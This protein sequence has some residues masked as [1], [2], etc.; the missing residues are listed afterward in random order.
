MSYF[1]K[2]KNDQFG[3]V[4]ILSLLGVMVITLSV[5]VLTSRLAISELQMM[6]GGGAMDQTY[7]AAE[8]GLNEALYRLIKSPGVSNY[9]FDISGVTIQRSPSLN[10]FLA[11][12]ILSP[13]RRRK[14]STRAF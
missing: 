6:R 12:A 1:F 13:V 2:I 4:A 11:S 5:V 3:V 7:Y 9:S 14:R 10:P 8:A